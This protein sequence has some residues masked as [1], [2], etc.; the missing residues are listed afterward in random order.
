MCPAVGLTQFIHELSTGFPEPIPDCIPNRLPPSPLPGTS[1]AEGALGP[2]PVSSLTP[3]VILGKSLP[4]LCLSFP[5]F[6]MQRV[7][8]GDL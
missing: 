5:I 6:V 4:T 3:R 7:G 1:E 2:W 8:I